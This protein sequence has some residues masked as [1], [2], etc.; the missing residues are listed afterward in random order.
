MGAP[1]LPPSL[2]SSHCQVSSDLGTVLRNFWTLEEVPS[3]SPLSTS[4]QECENHF[5]DNVRRQADGRYEVRLPFKSDPTSLGDSRSLALSMLISTERR[6]SRDD[7]LR[8]KY[9][10]FLE[11]YAQLGHLSPSNSSPPAYYLPHH[12]VF[13]TH[14][15]NGKLRVVFNAS[16]RTSSGLSLNDCL[17]VGPK[18]QSDLGMVL[19]RWRLFEFAFCADIV[20]MFRQISIHPDDRCWQ[21][22]LWRS[23]PS[24]AVEDLELNTVTYGTTSA[25]YLAIRTLLK[26]AEDEETNFPLGANALRHFS[27]VDDLLVGASSL[28]EALELQSQVTAILQ[29]GRF[30]LSRWSANHPELCP[31]SETGIRWHTQTDT[32]TLR[33][34]EP[35]SLTPT[36]TKRSILSEVA[37]IFDPLGWFSPVVIKAKILLQQLWVAGLDWDE[38]VSEQ[39][40]NTWLSLR[41]S[42]GQLD[43]LHIPRWLGSPGLKEGVHLV[44]FCDASQSAYAAAV[45]IGIGDPS[46]SNGLRLLMAKSKVAPIKP[47]TI[48]RLELCGALLLT[49]LLL[50][51]KQG[52]HLSKVT[53]KA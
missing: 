13:K 5:V 53:I 20:K 30:P 35:P 9:L 6:L 31:I 11:E 15:A 28:S 22:V 27:Y 17:H 29:S 46:S 24:L 34:F 2:S 16:S 43:T 4:E 36:W 21:R 19:S 42:M 41:E 50:A 10:E 12:G 33:A 47:V 14:D 45:Y 18:L 49:K 23:S 51:I 44:G 40:A 39:H 1:S 48:P 52:L 37:R 8:T 3:I 25:P 32:L 7:N 38:P 26:L